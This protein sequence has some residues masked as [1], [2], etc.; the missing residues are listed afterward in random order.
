MVPKDML[1]AAQA[2]RDNAHAPYSNFSVGACL[3][4]AEGRLFAGCNVEN[5]AYPQGWCAEVS[6]IGAMVAAG[7]SRIVEVLV[8][9]GGDELCTPCGGCRQALSEFAG[10]ETPVHVCGPEGPGSVSLRQ[11]MTLGE[12]MPYAFGPETLEGA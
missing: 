11:T 12:L 5:S 4:T 6:A 8:V 9:A 2:A 10:P 7:E 1:A 3:R